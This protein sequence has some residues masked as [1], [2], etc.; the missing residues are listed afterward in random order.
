MSRPRGLPPPPHAEGDRRIAAALA[1]DREALAEALSEMADGGHGARLPILLARAAATAEPPVPVPDGLRALR[2]RVAAFWLLIER[3]LAD[4]G[5][6]LAAAEVPWAPFKG[7]DVARRVYGDPT[8]RAMSDVDLLV[9]E[10][11]YRRAKAALEADGWT[12]A[13]PGPRFDRYVEEEGSAWTAG[14]PGSPLPVELHL[15][16][17]GFVPEGL[18]DTLLERSTADPALGATARRLRLA[19]AFVLA[20]V[21]PWLHLPPRSLANWWELRRFLA[22]GGPGLADEAAAFTE[23]HGLH[24]PVLLSAAQVAALWDEPLA[25][26]LAERLVGR[27]GAAERFAARRALGRPPNRV[28]IEWVAGARLVSGRRSRSGIKPLYR[29]LWAHPG[30]VER[31][32]PERWSWPR[33][34]TVHVLQCAGLLPRPRADW[35]RAPTHG[36]RAPGPRH[37]DS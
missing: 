29:R 15:R 21:H 12:N 25:A 10:R 24:L 28:P 11:D 18:G 13:A 36:H 22:V 8:L 16:L 14:R 4:F 6:A 7:A 3:D 30:I 27:L 32:T 1:G 34:R 17:W 31:L 19:D 2:T 23:D 5:R 26:G 33:R 9:R 20:A 37:D 35:W